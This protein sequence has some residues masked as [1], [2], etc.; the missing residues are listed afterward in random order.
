MS[1]RY[2]YG[3]I[4][5]AEAER[6]KKNLPERDW[7]A[8]DLLTARPPVRAAARYEDDDGEVDEEFRLLWA[9]TT[10]RE[11][12]RRFMAAA[13]AR[14]SGELTDD[15]ADRLFPPEPER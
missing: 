13:A 9:P 12:E 4:T 7:P 15:E 10:A 2:Q 1:K 11:R 6:M 8:I 5:P 14:H 3:W